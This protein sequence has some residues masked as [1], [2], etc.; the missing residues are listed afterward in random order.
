MTLINLLFIANLL[1][2]HSVSVIPDEHQIE[3]RFLIVENEVELNNNFKI[4][5]TSG[6]DTLFP[7]IGKNYFILSN[8]SRLPDSLNINFVYKDFNL[9]YENVKAANI[10]LGTAWVIKIDKKPF[11]KQ[12]YWY[13]K[14]KLRK[15]KWLYT[16][17]LGT[18]SIIT[19]YRFTKPPNF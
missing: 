5:F 2:F 12:E 16:L 14:S 8:V 9:V 10:L 6:S 11:D 13:L 19:V 4:Y 15:T 1:L 17:N 7:I 3:I 18:G